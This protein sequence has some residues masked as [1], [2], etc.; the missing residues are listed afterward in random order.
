VTITTIRPCDVPDPRK[1]FIVGAWVE[2][3]AALTID[4]VASTTQGVFLTVAEAQAPDVGRAVAAARAT[5]DT[6][7]S[8]RISPAERGVWD[9]HPPY[10]EIKSMI[11]ETAPQAVQ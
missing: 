4:E 7:P 5:F 2:P 3:S 9:G 11:F 8:L 1:F 10:L 6:G